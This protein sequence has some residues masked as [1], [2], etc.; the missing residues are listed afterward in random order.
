MIF[1][2]HAQ[3]QNSDKKKQTNKSIMTNVFDE[4][5]LDIEVQDEL[6]Q[7]LQSMLKYFYLEP[8]FILSKLNQFE[9]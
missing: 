3:K 6:F 9:P 2:S 7:T 8:S 1:L 5:K 4:E